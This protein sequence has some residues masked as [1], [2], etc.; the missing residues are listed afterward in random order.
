MNHSR[1]DFTGSVQ[2]DDE[3]DMDKTMTSNNNGMME[4]LID[5]SAAA[6]ASI[7]T[8]SASSLRTSVSASLRRSQSLQQSSEL[9]TLV[10]P[11][12]RFKKLADSKLE[13]L[14]INK[15]KIQSIGLVGRESET[16][17]LQSCLRSMMTMVDQQAAAEDNDETELIS[18]ETMTISKVNKELV[19]IKGFSGVGKSSLARTLKQQVDSTNGGDRY[20]VEGK[21]DLNESKEKPYAGIAKAYSELVGDLW[22]TNPDMLFAIGKQLCAMIGSEVEPLTYLIPELENVVTEYSTSS[23][24]ES[25]ID[26]MQERWKYSFRVLTRL[27]TTH[28]RRLWI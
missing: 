23:Y 17:R 12:S 24:S 22:T 9:T 10:E 7:N 8:T 2:T 25:N 28:L 27:L 1:V 13:E 14:T 19:F 11:T 20:Y 3:E 6:A 26:G 16:E 18:D 4:E 5:Y 21:F 15:L